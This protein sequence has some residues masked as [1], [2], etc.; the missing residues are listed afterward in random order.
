MKQ[1]GLTVASLAISLL[2]AGPLHAQQPDANYLSALLRPTPA[3]VPDYNCVICAPTRPLYTPPPDSP[4]PLALLPLPPASGLPV[5][6]CTFCHGVS[7]QGLAVAPRLAGQR[8]A[9]IEKEL[10]AFRNHSRDNPYS[11]LYMWNAVPNLYPETAR[12]LAEHFSREAPQAAAD[13]NSALVEQGRELY[14]RGEPEANIVTCVVCH[15][16]DAQGVGAIPRLAGLSYRYLKRRLDQ[17]NEGY[18]P[19]A[20]PMPQVT[21]SLSAN[22]IDALASYLSFLDDRAASR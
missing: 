6:N 9:Y 22:E 15:G 14:Q 19:T 11:A 4:Y 12:A 5:K 18:H 1:I 16:P 8:A 20:K 13:G 17:W 3:S 2:A 7:A 21:R 10:G